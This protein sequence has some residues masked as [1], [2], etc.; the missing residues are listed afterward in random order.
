MA[1]VGAES[2]GAG[3][4]VTGNSGKTE[5][6]A[7]RAYRLLEE[8]IVTLQLNP[9]QVISEMELSQ[10]LGVSRTP[11]RQALQRLASDNLVVMMPRRGLFISEIH[12]SDHLNLLET[13]RALDSLLVTSA[14]RRALPQQSRAMQDCAQDMRRAARAGDTASFMRADKRFD[15]LL[16]EA[17]RNRFAA[18]AATPLHAHCRRFWYLHRV[19]SHLQQAA[20]LH[21]ALIEAVAAGQADAAESASHA[22]I[23][24]LLEL[25]QQA[26]GAAQA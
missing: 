5:S 1:A 7:E 15:S 16:I 18:S 9:G 26:L 25:S 20:G 10:S 8:Q 14:A 6:L 21:C 24:Y 19:D 2:A 12:L 3:Q 17:A 23:D 13:R 11:L 22:L 4:A